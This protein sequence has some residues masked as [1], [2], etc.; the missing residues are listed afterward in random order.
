MKSYL[1]LCLLQF[2]GFIF[3]NPRAPLLWNC[4]LV[5]LSWRWNVW[6]C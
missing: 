2:F 1:K 6:Q 5:L 4:P 3:F